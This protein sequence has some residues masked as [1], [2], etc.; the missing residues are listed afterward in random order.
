MI[1]REPL[2]GDPPCWRHLFEADDDS[3]GVAGPRVRVRRVYDTL[4]AEDGFRVLVDRLW[5]RGLSKGNAH[6]DLWLRDLAPSDELRRWYGHDPG[7][8]DEFARRYRE[9]LAQSD[10][11]ALL[12]DLAQ[13]AST[14]TVT[15][16]C[17]A[18]DV[19][20][21]NAEVVR[22]VLLECLGS[23]TEAPGTDIS[24]RG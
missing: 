5:P 21:S 6:L 3:A 9:E 10:R 16:L 2:G 4:L 7:R 22:Q 20:R 1:D 11:Q 13:R 8:W 23:M 24:R 14:E 17:A 18:R 12:A 15:L 19:A